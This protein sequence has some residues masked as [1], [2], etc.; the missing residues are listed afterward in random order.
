[1]L[2]K[3]GGHEPG[4]LPF[5]CGW[6]LVNA[7]VSMGKICPDTVIRMSENVHPRYI[8]YFCGP[9]DIQAKVE[10]DI[11]RAIAESIRVSRLKCNS[12]RPKKSLKDNTPSS[13]SR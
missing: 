7:S 3:R 2:L 4:N 11:L 13:P 8:S 9:M 12:R 5:F 10:T 1:M 6:L